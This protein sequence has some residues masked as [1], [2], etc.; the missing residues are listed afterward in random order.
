MT[1]A[2]A[3]TGERGRRPE[4]SDA[5]IQTCL[6]MKVLFGMALRQTTGF[7]ES[8]LRP[9]GLDGAVPDFRTLPRRQKALK[10]DIP[11][12]R[13]DGPLHRLADSRAMGT[14]LVRETMARGIKIAGER[15]WNAR[16]HG[17][18]RRH[19]WRKIHI[20]I[21]AKTLEIRAVE[22]T[23]SG[24][25][26]APMLPERLDQI[27]P[28]QEIASVTAD[29]AFDTRKCHVA[30]AA[31]GAA[32]IPPRNNAKPWKPDT[33]G[34]PRHCPRTHGGQCLDPQRDPAHIAARRSHDLATMARASPPKPRR[35]QD[36]MR[37]AARPAPVRPGLR[38]SGRR[39]PGP[40]RSPERL[41]H[42]RHARPRGRRRGL[43]GERGTLSVTRFVQHSRPRP[44]ISAPSDV[45][46][47]KA[48]GL[49]RSA[50]PSPVMLVKQPIASQSERNDP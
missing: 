23:T 48:R 36:A 46:A 31:R 33:A 19:V 16:K 29:G 3:P 37:P 47:R 50:V 14:P 20:G 2:A 43:F 12:R 45:P 25:S 17:G 15:E 9:I 39:G 5:A 38:P 44:P 49:R 8:L 28:G 27:P 26:D 18:S 1:W 11:D 24:V 30:I 4:H 10:V 42:P 22:F 32:I 7:V 34:A 35:D 6:T 13:S 41:H 40:R 21:D